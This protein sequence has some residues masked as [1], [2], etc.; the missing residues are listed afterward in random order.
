VEEFEQTINREEHVALDSVV[1]EFGPSIECVGCDNNTF[2][3]KS[4]KGSKQTPVSSWRTTHGG[5][6][7]LGQEHDVNGTLMF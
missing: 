4:P 2:Q 3:T 1:W 5:G 7:E 6:K